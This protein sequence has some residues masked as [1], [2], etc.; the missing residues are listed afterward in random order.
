[1][2]RI[3]RFASARL[4][5]LTSQLLLRPQSASFSVDIVKDKGTGDEAVYFNKQDS[6]LASSDRKGH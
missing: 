4:P 2:F 3:A 5:Q 1:M 6:R